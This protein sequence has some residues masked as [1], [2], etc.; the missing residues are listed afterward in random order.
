MVP[1]ER[2]KVRRSR[3]G[4]AAPV[5]FIACCDASDKVPGS[6][7]SAGENNLFKSITK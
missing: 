3:K 2:L 1:S 7:Y 4:G 6:L 5:R